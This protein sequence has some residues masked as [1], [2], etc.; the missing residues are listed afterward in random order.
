VGLWHQWIHDPGASVTLFISAVGALFALWQLRWRPAEKRRELLHQMV[1]QFSKSEVFR[2]KVLETFPPL[3]LFAYDTLDQAIEAEIQKLQFAPANNTNLGLETRLN[4][5]KAESKAWR[6]S[7][8]RT[9]A[10]TSAK[11]ILASEYK[12]RA[13]MW[14]LEVIRHP[15]DWPAVGLTEDR[16][17]VA[18]DAVAKLN[19]FALD[20]ENGVYSPRSLFGQ[21]HLPIARIGAAIEPLVWEGGGNKPIQSDKDNETELVRA[22]QRW[23][24]RIVRLGIA[25]EH[26]NDVTSIHRISNITWYSGEFNMTVTVHPRVTLPVSDKEILDVSSPVV[27]HVLP[28]VRIRMVSSYWRLVGHLRPRP[29]LLWAYGGRRLRQH[30]QAEKRLVPLLN[31]AID[32]K[33]DH[34]VAA[35]LNFTWSLGSLP[36]EIATQVKERRESVGRLSWLY[37]P[38]GSRK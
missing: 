22:S 18:R 27:P 26:F 30:K 5:L 3:L 12:F 2:A 19:N 32:H 38:S 11:E 1:D 36:A 28:M 10:F 6:G 13:F 33:R 24:R 34:S 17:A 9:L 35:S 4:R 14:C 20:Y 15:P 8:Q 16:I 29:R 23:G 37:A 21:Y 25:A 7:S 31:Y